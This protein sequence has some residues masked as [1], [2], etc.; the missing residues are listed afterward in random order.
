MRKMKAVMERAPK[1]TKDDPKVEVVLRLLNLTRM[2]RRT[3]TPDEG[4]AAA[5]YEKQFQSD[6]EKLKKAA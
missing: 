2:L 5:E 1:A 6:L 4:I 3:G